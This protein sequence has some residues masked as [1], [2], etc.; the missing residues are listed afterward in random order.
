MCTIV[1]MFLLPLLVAVLG[2]WAGD[3]IL[4]GLCDEHYYRVWSVRRSLT[5]RLHRGR[6]RYPR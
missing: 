6:H 1:T 5:R 4:A 3:F 2:W